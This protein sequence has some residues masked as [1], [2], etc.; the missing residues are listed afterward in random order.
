MSVE[1]PLRVNL[2]WGGE[3]HYEGDFV[4]Y[5]PR[6]SNWTFTLRHR[7][8]YGELVDRIYHYMGVDKGMFK[9]KLFL[10]QL[11]ENSK[12][13]I[14]AV[15]D[16]E[17]LD[18]MYDLWIKRVSYMTEIYIEKEEIVQMPVVN[19]VFTGSIGNVGPMMSLVHAFMDPTKFN[20]GS[21]SVVPETSSASHYMHDDRSMD[22]LEPRLTSGSMGAQEY[23]HGLDSIPNFGDPRPSC[24]ISPHGIESN[25]GQ[26]YRSSA[27]DDV[28]ASGHDRL[29]VSEE[30]DPEVNAEEV[31]ESESQDVSG[32][33]SDDKHEGGGLRVNLDTQQPFVGYR[34]AN[35]E[36]GDIRRN[37]TAGS[38]AY[39]PR[40]MAFFSDLG[41][42]NDDDIKEEDGL[43]RIVTFSE[44]NNNIRLHM[45]FESK[46]QFS[47]VVRMLSINHNR[48]F[49]VI[50]SK[51]NTWFAKCKSSIERTPST[52][53]ALSYPPCD[54]CVRT[55]KKRTHGMWQITKW[56]NNHN[57]LGD[58]IRNN[59]TSLMASVISR[60][61]LRS[62]EDDNRLTV[63][64]ILSFVKENLKVDV[65]Y[66]KA[67]YT[68][69]KA[70]ELVFG[71]WEANFA[72][73]PQYLD[74]LVQSD[75]S[76]V[77]EWSN[78]SDSSD[79]VQTFKYVFWAFGPAIEAFHMCRPVIC[80][81]G[82]HLCG[83][84]KGKTPCCGHSRCEQ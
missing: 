31:E 13:T 43:E 64:N 77:V 55:V 34:V 79:R 57:C 21:S 74:A 19:S 29:L 36:C 25:H 56:I 35:T 68:R 53:T 2:Y 33:D 80:V 46:L 76:T 1:R 27:E 66:K 78:H 26:G 70:I 40:G 28:Y 84:Y 3:I 8:G 30:D 72:E 60:H 61:I 48:E 54:W 51:S 22:S 39:V 41:S 52:S 9:L 15:V 16:D 69:R 23:F 58:M 32:S 17:T 37:S 24:H 81:D 59:N 63:K 45:R 65:S 11:L 67:W 7:I 42:I 6:T 75:S 10:R 20:S 44:E 82:T 14:S 4:C 18:V 73:L 38:S 12:Y 47:R 62:I 50:E 5:L 49:R 83:E 71:S